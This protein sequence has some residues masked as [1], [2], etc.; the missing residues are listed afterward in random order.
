[1]TLPESQK[2]KKQIRTCSLS[3]IRSGAYGRILISKALEAPGVK[4]VL[5][6]GSSYLFRA[7]HALPPLMTPSGQPTGAIYG[8]ANMLRRL[9]KEESPTHIGVVFDTKGKNFRHEMYSEYKAN[10]PPM[11]DDL[12][13]QIEPLHALIEAMGL[14][15]LKV[16]G[17]EADDVIG[18]LAK[19]ATDAGIDTVISTSDKDLAQLVTEHV[20]LVNTMTGQRLNEHGVKEKFGVNPDQ[21][22][23]YLALMGDTSDNVPGIPKV[24]PKTAV[25]WLTA[26]KTLDGVVENAAAITGKV[27]ENLRSHLEQ[28]K[29]S[30]ALVTIKL[31]VPL[32]V[33][34]ADL[35]PGDPNKV[36]LKTLYTE[37]EFKAW[38]QMMDRP[39]PDSPAP[40]EVDFEQSS[41][42]TDIVLTQAQLDHWV[43]KLTKA[44]AFVIDTETDGLDYMS[45]QLVGIALSTDNSEGAY[46]PLAHDYEDAPEQLDRDAVL[47]ALSVF[48]T[49]PKKT[50]IGHHLKFDAHILERYGIVLQGPLE[51]TML[52]SYAL[53][54]TITRHNMDSVAKHYLNITTI[55]YEAV[56]GKGVKQQ[57]LNSVSI[58]KVGPYAAEDAWVTYALFETLEKALT[59]TLRD[60][61]TNIERPL[62]R[63]LGQMEHLGV[64]IDSQRLVAQ[65][66]VLERHCAELTQQAH[67]FVGEEFNLGSPKQLQQILYEKMGL[68]VLQ[69]T[70]KGQ[71]STSEPVLTE[72]AH[73]YPLPRVILSYRSL[74]KLKSTYTDKLPLL[75]NPTT[76]RVHTSYHQAVVATG[77]LSS[78]DPNLQNIPVRTPEGRQIREAF[79]AEKGWEL[80]AAD[81]SQIELRIMAHLS[82]DACLIR[83]FEQ[84]EDI[85]RFTASEI[86]Q[87]PADEVTGEQRRR[88]KAIN[89]GL[90]YG[91]SAFGLAKQIGVDRGVAQ[92]YMN[93]YFERYPGVKSYMEATRVQATDQGYVETLF[94]R[95]L[96]LQ[97]INS[98]N[99]N[100]RKAAQRA[101]INAPMQG[102]AADLIKRAMIAVSGALKSVDGCRLIMQVHD[103][104]VFEMK[105]DE[106]EQLTP[107]IVQAMEEAGGD[108][109]NVPLTVS[110][111]HGPHWEAAH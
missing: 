99:M 93:E 75:V 83:A 13:V 70:P 20:G 63:I 59:G 109:L 56:A 74:S 55:P 9:I 17:V 77:R 79:I 62:I 11:P 61:Y 12:R 40:P 39:T 50:K 102:T 110:V 41:G 25:K 48:L 3:G 36:A 6:D 105:A 18:T 4:F 34:P 90:I 1:M 60:V 71:P 21:M 46:I 87:V 58:D 26:Y 82:E 94:G 47:K 51:D 85:H 84:G 27:G 16:E 30:Q 103:E 66:A 2:Q 111:G 65:S 54:P 67:D 76:H 28:L 92:Q 35:L 19:K 5:V 96:Y 24:G 64:L 78:S 107:M 44:K 45:A 106:R 101:A 32:S 23:D 72:L 52:M 7:Y 29:L 80:V 69:K 68:P 31:D 81:Y 8:V 88:A 104:L 57:T 53:N 14:P 100:L 49:D 89:F 98:R 33:E 91:M 15:I 38:L 37:L 73:T 108:K 86:F 43:G 97:D 95:R 42:K 10:R 22:I